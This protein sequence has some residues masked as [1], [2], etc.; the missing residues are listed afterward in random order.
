MRAAQLPDNCFVVA[1]SADFE[2]RLN[3]LQARGKSS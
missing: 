1:G 3:D 2:S